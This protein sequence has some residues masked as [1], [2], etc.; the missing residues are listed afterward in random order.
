M[1]EGK[2]D[3]VDNRQASY[4]VD[5]PVRLWVSDH[6]VVAARAVEATASAM[7]VHLTNWL[8][9]DVFAI[10]QR[11]RISVKSRDGEEIVRV[12]E[13]RNR[14]PR[15]LDLATTEPLLGETAAAGV[16]S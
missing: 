9:S 2:A 4:T 12:A 3:V 5:W 13:I 15:H 1:T 16:V 14:S 10:G 11:Y 7:R 8:P 6:C